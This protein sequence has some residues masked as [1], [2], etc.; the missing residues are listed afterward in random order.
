[1]GFLVLYWST[2]IPEKGAFVPLSDLTFKNL[3]DS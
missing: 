1:M 3:R 2:T